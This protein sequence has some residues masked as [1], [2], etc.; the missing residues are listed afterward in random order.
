MQ[1]GRHAAS[2]PS[3]DFRAVTRRL[4]LGY[5]RASGSSPV[6]LIDARDDPHHASAR[7]NFPGLRHLFEIPD[8]GT[9][10]KS[11]DGL[12]GHGPRPLFRSRWGR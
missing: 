2:F 6:L 1:G 12:S 11:E 10:G 8:L 7:D 5:E 9:V 3:G 4:R